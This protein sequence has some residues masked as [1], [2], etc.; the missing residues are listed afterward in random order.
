MAHAYQEE[1]NRFRYDTSKGIVNAILTND[2]LTEEE[3]SE[4]IARTIEEFKTEYP[5]LKYHATKNDVTETE[6]RLT[7]EIEE[8]RKEIEE[9]RKEIKEVEFKLSMEI[10]EVRKEIEVVRKEIKGVELKLSMEI[11]EVRKE[12]KEVELRLSK[13][14]KETKAVMI[15]WSFLFWISQMGALLGIGFFIFKALSL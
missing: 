13:E 14:I 15:K 1:V 10:E 9:V 8:T 4:L 7:K 2:K 12:I 5:D 11:E 6:L 3:K